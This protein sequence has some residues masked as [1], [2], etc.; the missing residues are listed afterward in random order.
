MSPEQW[1]SLF[2]LFARFSALV[3]VLP[4]IAWRGVPVLS[5]IGFSALLSFLIFSATGMEAGPLPS[6]FLLFVL[7]AAGDALFGLA[8]GFLAVLTFTAVR[9]AG[10]LV[11]LQSGLLMS[12]V[13]DPQYGGQETVFGQFYYSF[14]IVLFL[15]LNAHH[16]L[17]AA[18][19]RSVELV[20]PGSLGLAPAVLPSFL[21]LF[22]QMFI[23]AFQLAAP[24]LIVLILTD[25]ALGLISK[26]VPQLQVFIEGMPLKVGIALLI[27]YI[28][29]PY[30]AQALESMF[31]RLTEDLFLLF[32]LFGAPAG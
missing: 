31:Y 8:L 27:V 5:R 30:F 3:S 19:V 26:T 1:S 4:F 17:L 9:I 15:T 13:L 11:D 20:P 22:S 25:I 16:V 14:A 21:A 24:V 28:I 12:A 18:L 23:L 7:A 29:F 32:G 2:L 10:Q 6:H